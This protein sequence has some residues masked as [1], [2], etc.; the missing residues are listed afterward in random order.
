MRANL[1]R[2]VVLPAVMLAMTALVVAPGPAVASDL[3]SAVTHAG[4][5][6]ILPSVAYRG[7]VLTLSGNGMT[8]SRKFD[9]GERLSVGLFDSNGYLLPD[10][11][12]KWRLA[13]L[14]SEAVAKSLRDGA[15]AQGWQAMTGSFTLAQGRVADPA[16]TEASEAAYSAVQK[17]AVTRTELGA[18]RSSV[19]PPNHRSD[20]AVAS[21][22]AC[23]KRGVLSEAGGASSTRALTSGLAQPARGALHDGDEAVLA[24]VSAES[25]PQLSQN[26]SSKA[27]AA[28]RALRPQPVSDGSNGRTPGAR[29]DN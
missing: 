15:S 23:E 28:T 8:V 7:A 29:P 22:Q 27:V 16:L 6:D 17:A 20:S 9:A 26:A 14:P 3:A 2:N 25:A 1:F 4:G 11:S 12:Y 10:G 24:G 21:G 13:L 19:A 18:A 5:V